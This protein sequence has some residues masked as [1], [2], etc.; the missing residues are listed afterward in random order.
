MTN[1]P[2]I[3]R[4]LAG[5]EE[6]VKSIARDDIDRA[7][8]ALYNAW[9]ER[10]AVFVAGNGGSAGTATHFA[11]DLNKMTAIPGR[12]RLRAMSLG[13]NVP[14]VSAI[15]NDDGWENLYTEQLETFFAPRDVLV[16]ISVHGGKGRDRAGAWS[17]NLVRAIEW[18]KA[19]GGTTIGLVGFDG[20]VMREMCDIC[21]VVPYRTTPHVE[22]FHV[23]LHH[24]I[25]FCLA[26]RIA[27]GAGL[28]RA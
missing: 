27:G 11:A 17:Q 4:F 22:G 13:D 28:A 7:I 23:V 5:V 6:I 8:E 26:E 12:P 15:I 20:G 18:V 25:A 9:A 1:G 19:R 10:R 3:D 2:Y 24:L 14:L 16:T 21:I